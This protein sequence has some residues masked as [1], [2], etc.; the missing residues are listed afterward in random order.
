LPMLMRPVYA[1]D[2]IFTKIFAVRSLSAKS[3]ASDCP[4]LC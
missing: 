2:L 4:I 1:Q 3:I